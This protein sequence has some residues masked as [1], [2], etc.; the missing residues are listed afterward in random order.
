MRKRTLSLA[1]AALGLLGGAGMVSAKRQPCPAGRYVV[2]GGALLPGAPTSQ[3]D[4]VS[5]GGT[6]PTAELSIG[7]T[8]AHLKGAVKVEAVRRGT[9]V[10]AQWRGCAGL[11]KVRL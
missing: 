11:A 8:A 1:I 6:P 10:A 3:V 2:Q 5:I 7:C 4:V 9:K